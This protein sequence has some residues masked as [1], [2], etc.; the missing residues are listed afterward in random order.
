VIDRALAI[1]ARAAPGVWS[2]LFGGFVGRNS[3]G[4]AEVMLAVA[5][6]TL[7]GV[8]EWRSPGSPTRD[9]DE[10]WDTLTSRQKRVVA[11]ALARGVGVADRRLAARVVAVAEHAE[12]DGVRRVSDSIWRVAIL[13]LVVFVLVTASRNGAPAGWIVASAAAA[14]VVFAAGLRV[15]T[16]ATAARARRTAEATRAAPSS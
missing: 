13:A 15:H 6:A 10:Y 3:W 16:P 2:G 4:I 12:R 1:A 7:G 5:L 8:G 11:S 9:F 14:G